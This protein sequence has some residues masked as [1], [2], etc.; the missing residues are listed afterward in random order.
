MEA[1]AGTRILWAGA[2][3]SEKAFPR[4]SY[5][6]HA[7]RHVAEALAAAEA[8]TASGR[9]YAVSFLEWGEGA[10]RA[11]EVCE[12]LRLNPE[13]FVVL[14]CTKEDA[15]P[16]LSNLPPWLA[17]DRCIPLPRPV[18]PFVRKS[19]AEH[20]GSRWRAEEAEK[21]RISLIETESLSN[22]AT[23]ERYEKRLTVLYGIAEKI[24]GA[25]SLEEALRVSLEEISRFLGARTGS[26]LLL[27]GPDRLRVLEA[28]GPQ[29]EKILGISV[30]L[31]ESRISRFALEEQEPILVEDI[32]ENERFRESGEA[33]RFRARSILSIPLFSQDAP[34]GVLN[35]GGDARE[36]S[37]TE[38]DRDLAVTLGRQVAVALEKARLLNGL[39]KALE[40]SIRALA[41]AIEAKDRYT[42]GHSDR[43]THYA[44]LMA[45]SM[46]LGLRETEVLIQAAILHDVGKIGVPEL[47]LN[48]PTRL[49]DEEFD[50]IRRHPE[51]GV[52][53]VREIRAMVETLPII[54]SHHE[55][56]D[57]RGYPDGTTGEA[58]PLGA[59]ILA[60]ADTFD[61]MT[62]SRPYRRGLPEGVA[63][64]EIERCSGTQFDPEVARVFLEGAL[65]WPDT[66][67]GPSEAADRYE[68]GHFFRSSRAPHSP[69]AAFP[70]AN[71]PN[72]A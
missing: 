60:V 33:V 69:S 54:R 47:V 70:S 21:R 5:R 24:H 10:F 35:F 72:L 64:E 22:R 65:S 44:R 4:G 50:L 30:P 42:R 66:S 38:H 3:A 48:K 27:E 45:R 23:H 53:I 34:L 51:V 25:V 8:S 52:E 31:D 71:S 36:S 46:G 58:I 37:F 68:A 56:F 14:E 11:G 57:G 29:S 49:S 15:P 17:P 20:L 67:P 18:N 16:T 13:L 6:V 61:A 62:S 39:Q 40:E 12:L 55:R 32:Q 59:R 43:V 7:V 9:P 19:L 1:R 63:L 28:V 26:L 41:G 2:E